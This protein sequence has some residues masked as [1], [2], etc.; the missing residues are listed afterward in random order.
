M[1]DFEDFLTIY[2]CR[3]GCTRLDE[4]GHE[5]PL[6]GVHEGYC[7]RCYGA[8]VAG[9]T[10]AA[11]LIY[12]LLSMVPSALRSKPRPDGSQRTKA[13]TAPLPFDVNAR[14]DAERIYRLTVGARFIPYGMADIVVRSAVRERTEHLLAG[15]DRVLAESEVD[16]IGRLKANMQSIRRTALKWP[17]EDKPT[18]SPTTLCPLCGDRVLIVPPIEAGGD[19]QF[20]CSKCGNMLTEAEHEQYGRLTRLILKQKS[21]VASAKAA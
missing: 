11:P 8:I 7:E 15:L 18:L 20:A 4:D 10:L 5:V 14:D 16:K 12:H 9:L 2:P 19:R 3:L 13:A 17:T 1:N 21:K 6:P